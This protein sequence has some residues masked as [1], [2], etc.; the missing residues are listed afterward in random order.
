MSG[1]ASK[2]AET[3]LLRVEHGVAWIT[4]NRPDR[5]NAFAGDMRDRLHDAIDAAASSPEVRVLVITGAGR[6]F[7]TGADVEVMSDL[8][9]RGDDET[10]QTLVQAGMRVVQRLRSVEQ[11]V[12]AAVNGPAAGAGA[13]LALACDFRVASERA[14]IGITFNRIGLHPDWGV[15]WTLP[16]LVGAGRAAE[17]VMSGRMVEAREAE[18][19]GLFERVLAEDWFE[20]EVKKLARDLAAKPP[21]ALRLARRTL[22][23]SLDSDLHTMLAAERDQ[24]MRCF[25]SADARE[26]I[27]AFNEKRNP[28]FRGE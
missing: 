18:R 7:C 12:I 20:D 27:A 9:Q 16:R 14:S 17:L 4:L 25:R 2:S 21:L 3:V 26:G 28:V 23:A 15:T 8:L 10:F 5:L 24:Q 11:P 6:G 22:A 19:M 13:S 1:R